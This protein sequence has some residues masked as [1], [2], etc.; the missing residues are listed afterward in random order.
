VAGYPRLFAE[1]RWGYGLNKESGTTLAC[2]VGTV[3]GTSG[4][5][6]SHADAQWLNSVADQANAKIKAAVAQAHLHAKSRSVA[7]R[8]ANV[9]K[10]FT[11]HRICSGDKWING[12]QMTSVAD[13]QIPSAKRTSFHPAEA[14][15]RAY[16]RAVLPDLWSALRTGF[17]R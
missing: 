14:G 5:F 16:A 3:A 8:Y 6:I 12:A 4:V 11:D 17:S 9:S 15:Q 13:R 2:K 1:S 10:E 7:V